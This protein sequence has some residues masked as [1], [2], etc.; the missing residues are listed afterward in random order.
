ME[1][2]VFFGALEEVLK[3]WVMGL[4]PDTDVDIARTEHDVTGLLVAGFTSRA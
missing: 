2:T 4:L 1:A 3:G